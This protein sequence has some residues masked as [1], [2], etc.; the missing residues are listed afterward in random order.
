MTAVAVTAGIAA[1]EPEDFVHKG[2][3]YTLG[4]IL[5]VTLFG[6]VDR[7][8]LTLAAAPMAKELSLSD[9]QLGLV[10]GLAF[11]IFSLVATFPLAWAADRFDRRYVLSACVL[12][13]SIG[14]ALC[15]LAQSFEQLFLA[16]VLIA[17]GEAGLTPICYA[18]VPDLFSG[19]KRTLANGLFYLF[20]FVGVSAGLALGGGAL[21]ALDQLHD[22]LPSAL[23]A[24]SSWRLSF[25]AVASPAPIFMVLTWFATLRRRVA[26]PTSSKGAEDLGNF[27]PFLRSHWATLALVFAALAFYFLAFGGYL[28]WL[29][30]AAARVFNAT[31]AANGL[32]MAAATFVGMVG[33]VGLGQVLMRL[34]GPQ[35]GLGAP[36]RTAFVVALAGTPIVLG[37]PFI[38]AAWQGYAL[39][40]ALMLVGTTI[41]SL[42][43]SILQD[44]APPKLRARVAALYTIA[45]GL[46]G[47]A[48]PTLVGWV[49]GALGKDPR[50]LLVAITIVAL[51]T[52]I[53]TVLLFRLSQ[54]RFA[55][56]AGQLATDAARP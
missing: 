41:G 56:L 19:R 27:M 26:A 16:A 23:R 49:S 35:H 53:V 32:G 25:F 43:P 40:G 9:G 12:T 50:G 6:F 38:Q 2:G 42:V 30:V 33:G 52:W 5:A 45:A 4:V 28:S 29:P 22:R 37:F 44:L 11:A 10:Q 24:F 31:P 14:T 54:R 36:I 7:Q 15:G 47:G 13:W 8:V 55:D 3:W 51:P 18:V 34:Y 17:A 39:F 46:I 21:S 1:A 20:S 48:A